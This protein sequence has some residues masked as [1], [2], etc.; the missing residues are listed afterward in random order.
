M[1]YIFI[2]YVFGIVDVF[3]ICLVKLHK[4]WLWPKVITVFLEPLIALHW[5]SW[6][7]SVMN[8]DRKQP[9]YFSPDAIDLKS[10]TLL[11]FCYGWLIY[12]QTL[13]T[14]RIWQGSGDRNYSCIHTFKDHIAEVS[15]WVDLAPAM[16]LVCLIFLFSCL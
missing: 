7:I 12:L 6:I 11:R 14:V 5:F 1:K 10:T 16:M 2:W 13:Q 9:R 15:I 8:S 3:Y 4:V